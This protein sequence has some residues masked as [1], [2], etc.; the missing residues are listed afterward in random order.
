MH[1]DVAH[2]QV[3]IYQTI[4]AI[5]IHTLQHYN[6]TLHYITS[7]Y[8]PAHQTPHRYIICMII[9]AGRGCGESSHDHVTSVRQSAEMTEGSARDS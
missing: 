1:S 2:S 3:I 8:I 5:H 7:H 6:I 4:S 9:W